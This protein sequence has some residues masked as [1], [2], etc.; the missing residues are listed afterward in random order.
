M[1]GHACQCPLSADTNCHRGLVNL[2]YFYLTESNLHFLLFDHLFGL[3]FVLFILVGWL[4]Y[5]QRTLSNFILKF[6]FLLCIP[7]ALGHPH[8]TQGLRLQDPGKC[9]QMKKRYR[10]SSDFHHGIKALPCSP[11]IL[12][13]RGL[14]LSLRL[15]NPRS[16]WVESGDTVQQRNDATSL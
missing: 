12:H 5:I 11:P 1:G 13:P 14:R 8:F 15:Q 9:L 4:P 10:W 2:N 7:Q 6:R 16:L 3:V